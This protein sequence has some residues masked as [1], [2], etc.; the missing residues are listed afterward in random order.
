MKKSCSPVVIGCMAGS[1]VVAIGLILLMGLVIVGM[2]EEYYEDQPTQQLA[3]PTNAPMPL[4]QVNVR[5]DTSLTRARPPQ[6]IARNLRE[7][8]VRVEAAYE[9]QGWIFTDFDGG[10][11]SGFIIDKDEDG[12]YW[13]LTNSHVMLMDDL[14][15][16]GRNLNLNFYA[17]EVYMHD[18]QR[19]DVLAALEHNAADSA[20]LIVDGSVG[21]YP[22]LPITDKEPE[23]GDTVYAMG[24]PLGLDFTFTQG[25][26]SSL[27]MDI[28]RVI[29]TDTMINPGNSGGPLANEYGEVV[30]LNSFMHADGVGLNFAL[31][32]Q[33]LIE[34]DDYA[35]VPLHNLNELV[36][37]IHTLYGVR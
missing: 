10:S 9:T 13:I 6:E 15:G 3:G 26:V 18:G 36:V 4:E 16:K 24:H 2:M 25:S 11:G 8:V 21:N 17:V 19:A 31:Y 7:G 34:L 27:R 33:D 30:G 1:L 28:T 5:E 37:H 32:I 14:A 12:D 22:I 20:I 35:I 29:Q 23:V